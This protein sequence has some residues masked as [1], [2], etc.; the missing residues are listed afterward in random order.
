MPVADLCEPFSTAGRSAMPGPRSLTMITKLCGTAVAG[1]A[2]FDLA[3]AGVFKS[4]AGDFRHRGGDPGLILAFESDQFRQ[5][6]RAL[7]D[8]NDVG[9]G[10]DHDQEQARIHAATL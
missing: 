3:A 2:E 6:P 4:I 8:Q 9:L 7:A 1:E 10:A 5:P